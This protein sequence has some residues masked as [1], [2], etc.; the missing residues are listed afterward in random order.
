M[1]SAVTD[2]WHSMLEQVYPQEVR[3]NPPQIRAWHKAYTD[4]MD[5]V[6]MNVGFFRHAAAQNG[7]VY[8]AS[9]DITDKERRKYI[10]APKTPVPHH[11]EQQNRCSGKTGMTMSMI[12][13]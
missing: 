10:Y 7:I 4:K 2:L 6:D 12:S 1:D 13:H 3:S 8:V 11:C 9:T 5:V